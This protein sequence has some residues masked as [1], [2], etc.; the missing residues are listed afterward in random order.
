MI[1][2][3]MPMVSRGWTQHARVSLPA[4]L[5]WPIYLA[6]VA[7]TVG[8]LAMRFRQSAVLLAFPLAYYAVAGSGYTVF[9]RYMIPELP[10]LCI[11]AAWLAVTA[12]R[13]LLRA[14]S[15]LVRHAPLHV[16]RASATYLPHL[17]LAAVALVMVAPSARQVFRLDQVLARTDNRVIVARALAR[18][19]PPG[20][21][22]YHSGGAY[23]HVPYDLP[24]GEL[25]VIACS[26]DEQTGEFAPGG[27]LPD[28]VIVQ[29]SPLLLY[30]HVPA[31]LERIVRE[32]Y[33]L[34]A[35]FRTLTSGVDRVYDQQDAFFLPEYGL[36]GIRRPGPEFEIYQRRR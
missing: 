27:R 18:L 31:A 16:V 15:P 19:I 8:L 26:Y 13:A 21:S 29:R 4:A 36:E 22:V 14:T 6:G 3:G 2:Q 35:S 32:S 10:F 33:E 1:G 25:A 20:S 7:G 28:W 24:G 17:A 12:V 34:V 9:A 5:G 30:S 11:S 23:G